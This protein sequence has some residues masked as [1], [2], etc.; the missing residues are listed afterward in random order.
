MIR[1]AADDTHV[2][3][4]ALDV[5]RSFIVQ[6]PAG[7][8]KTELL[9]Q[10]FLALL[11]TVAFPEE[12]VAI[13]FTRKATAEMR[14]RVLLALDAADRPPPADEHAR[15]T[16]TL[17]R[18]VIQ[19]DRDRS[20]ALRA[21]PSRLRIHT[22][23][24]LC[25]RLA[26]QM[27]WLSRLAGD[28]LPVEDA[29]EYYREAARRTLALLEEGAPFAPPVSALLAHLDND[30]ARFE[31]MIETMLARRDQWL[32][33]LS[34][35]RPDEGNFRRELESALERT[36][37]DSLEE[38]DAAIPGLLRQDLVAVGSYA[39]ENLRLLEAENPV[40]RLAGI[41]EL[42]QPAHP[43]LDAWRA[44]A[45][46]LLTQ[47]G[48]PRKRLNKSVGIP[49]DKSPHAV[50]M[51][52]RAK[53]LLAVLSGEQQF[54]AALGT[55]RD[56]PDP[57]YGDEQ[58][59]VLVAL[60]E[61]LRFSS[62][63]LRLVFAESG[64]VDFVELLSAARR[65]LG[66]EE[67]PTDLALSLDYRI[68]HILVDEFQD[69][70]HS[71]F[72]LLNQLTAGW[73]P[74]DQ[75]TLF[76][77]GDPMQS[78]YR[79]READVGVFLRAWHKG[80]RHVRLNRLAL[81]ANFRSTPGII[82]WVNGTFPQVFP[83]ADD[84]SSGAV[85]YRPCA[86]ALGKDRGNAVALHALVDPGPDQ[87]AQVVVECVKEALSKAPQESIA[88]L[89]RSRTHL[90]RILQRLDAG[91][92]AHRGVELRPVLTTPAVHDLLS[93]T[94][95]LTHPADRVA[96][97]AVLRAPW[98]GLL[99]ADL[100]ALAEAEPAR[101]VPELL[102]DPSLL[103]CLSP[104]GQ[105]RL[106]RVAAVMLGAMAERGRKALRRQVEGVWQALG[107]PAC[108]HRDAYD[109]AL[110]CLDLIEQMETESQV[111]DVDVLAHR[112]EA[113]YATPVAGDARVEVMTIHK[114]KGLEFDTVIVP[115]LERA[116]PPE[117]KRLLAW[118]QRAAGPTGT[119]LLLAPLPRDDLDE[120]PVYD[121]LNR[122]EESKRQLESAR[123]LYV[124]A[125]RARRRLHLVGSAAR[126]A[127]AG[128]LRRPPPRSLLAHLWPAAQAEFLRA[129]AADNRIPAASR[130]QTDERPTGSWRL[131]SAWVLPQPAPPVGARPLFAAG[132][133]EDASQPIIFEWAGFSVRQVGTVV[134]DRLRLIAE[135]GV[136]RWSAARIRA[137]A[138]SLRRALA[139]E[140]M[141]DAQLKDS[142]ETVLDALTA[143][144]ADPTGQWIL[145][146]EHQ[147]A[148]N[149]LALS[150]VLDGRLVSVYIDRTFVDADG[151]RWIVD[152]K[153]G[154]HE[155]ASR[156]DFLD[157]EQ[158]RYAPQL[159]RYARLMANIEHR[160]ISVGLYLP[161]LGGWRCW[162][163]SL[164]ERMD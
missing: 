12:V 133:A 22:I 98:C 96:W 67:T 26:R 36:V 44:L 55:V 38:V 83:H 87:A 80:L 122:A 28:A 32:K 68:A 31:S 42:P 117:G 123:L 57:K 99:L 75:R 66:D 131:P 85:G 145:S 4:E 58:W 21:N 92:I 16:Y 71:Q 137:T 17:A 103:P 164:K 129:E 157:R 63:L 54:I 11:A 138:P 141:S 139:A 121:F 155:G 149:E 79:F 160:P 114:A 40:V 50:A 43:Q 89:V 53:A 140:G 116:P 143:V 69:T 6:A 93:L 102:A 56:M 104:D 119:D 127:E 15:R 78:I 77:V 61:V 3:R 124:A 35:G 128:T 23:D 101:C 95:A 29:G 135:E 73:I 24:G 110:I 51:K 10:R 111:V 90:G 13:T 118:T 144:L 62:G 136:E 72:Q 82:D 88:I 154:R 161:L 148:E 19:R 81:T 91:G 18:A 105:K 132:P 64:R 156:D 27:P 115:A 47:E 34:K 100:A 151:V 162:T 25:A 59:A 30:L 152:Y 9:I 70:S 5:G 153:S 94:R 49:A 130:I 134:H 33:V 2:R 8:G 45:S 106:V 48:V 113:L 1:V 112:L 65:A 142:L 146:A 7:S 163:P 120:P 60:L 107:G 126:G 46:L 14:G 86:S 84:E 39:G 76:L 41:T 97:L 20:W 74:D 158:E 159:E 109:D 108:V 147:E 150:G 37:N 52:D 125:T